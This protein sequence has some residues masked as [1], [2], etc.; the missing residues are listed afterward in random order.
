MEVLYIAVGAQHRGDRSCVAC[1]L[2]TVLADAGMGTPTTYQRT[3]RAQSKQ[4]SAKDTVSLWKFTLMLSLYH[5]LMASSAWYE[6]GGVHVCRVTA[7][8]WVRMFAGSC[9]GNCGIQQ[10]ARALSI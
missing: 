6:R 2:M 8:D 5:A 7:S 3:S 4:G 9:R 1:Q 10:A